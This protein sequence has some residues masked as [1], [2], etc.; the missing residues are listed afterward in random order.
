MRYGYTVICDARDDVRPESITPGDWW[1][2]TRV[3]RASFRRNWIP[4]ANMTGCARRHI[5]DNK[6]AAALINNG[7]N[8][9][10]AI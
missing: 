8:N 3:S 1:Y 9:K 7:D 10:A 5:S 4:T 6:T 2:R